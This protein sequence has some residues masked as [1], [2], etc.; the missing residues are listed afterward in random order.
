MKMTYLY[1]NTRGKHFDEVYLNQFLTYKIDSD[2]TSYVTVDWTG[3]VYED[4]TIMDFL[5]YSYPG[6]VKISDN[7]FK[8]ARR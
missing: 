8:I 5:D 2:G 4:D 1:Y 6:L 7:C 3:N